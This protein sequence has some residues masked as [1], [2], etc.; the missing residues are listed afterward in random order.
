MKKKQ[1]ERPHVI[2]QL[3]GV[4][5]EGFGQGPLE[6]AIIRVFDENG[7]QTK[8]TPMSFK[9]RRRESEP[10]PPPPKRMLTPEDW[11]KSQGK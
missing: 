9:N 1:E 3:L 4:G 2:I 7:R 5:K 10:P 6:D 11:K 8:M